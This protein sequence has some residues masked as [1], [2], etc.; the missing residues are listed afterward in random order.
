LS[1]IGFWGVT[2]ISEEVTASVFKVEKW[3][4]PSA[5]KLEGDGSFE[6]LVIIYHSTRRHTQEAGDIYSHR[7]ENQRYQFY[8]T[9]PR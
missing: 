8:Y 2:D 7:R 1:I 5:L 4:I 3:F 6:K 9:D